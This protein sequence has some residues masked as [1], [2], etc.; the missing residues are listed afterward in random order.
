MKKKLFTL[1][2]LCTV[3]QL[4]A[5]NLIPLAY[6]TPITGL[7]FIREQNPYM[8]RQQRIN[9]S[10]WTNLQRFSWAPGQLEKTRA[11][12]GIYQWVN[13]TWQVLRLTTRAFTLNTNNKYSTVIE[14]DE[15]NNQ[16]Y[17]YRYTYTYNTDQTINT[18]KQEEATEFNGEAY[19]PVFDIYFKYNA[20]G[21]R[22]SDST[23][24]TQFNQ[25]RINKY[26]YN[27]NKQ[28]IS[29]TTLAGISGDSLT[30]TVYSYDENKLS[31]VYGLTFNPNADSWETSEADTITYTNGKITGRITYGFASVNGGGF[32]FQPFRNET[33]AYDAN[34]NLNS[35]E[36][37]AWQANAWVN[38]FMLT[39]TYVDGKLTSAWRKNAVNGVYE[40]TASSRYLFS[41]PSGL[42][43]LHA[44]THAI[45]LYPNP[46]TTFIQL[47]P[48][49][50]LDEQKVYLLNSLGKRI[51]TASN[52]S[53]RSNQL[54]VSALPNGLYFICIESEYGQVY[55]GK[56]WVNHP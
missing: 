43:T 38:S 27:S 31:I 52:L 20:D 12:D 35:I 6:E 33:Y 54:D 23:Y 16:Q 18:I 32:A 39:L 22:Q 1:I 40:A 29:A 10:T 36:F 30:K 5:Q 7:D 14:R 25:S 24:Y 44:P 51:E 46:A 8:I 55:S 41:I 42:T 11:V 26:F 49:L 3:L 34:G 9:D 50:A 2:V 53:L 47:N 37:K 4:N 13:N 56:F 19:Q 48:D 21:T 15:F 45:Q 17:Q 28:L